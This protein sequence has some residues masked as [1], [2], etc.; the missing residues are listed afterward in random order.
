MSNKLVIRTN[1]SIREAD[2]N[3]Y[4][5]SMIYPC[6]SHCVDSPYTFPAHLII[7]LTDL[8]QHAMSVK[9]IWLPGA[10]YVFAPG[11]HAAIIPLSSLVK[12]YI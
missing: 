4:G 12:G 3:R 5:C 9:P 10:N 8:L 6:M 11:F 7:F 1:L 2:I